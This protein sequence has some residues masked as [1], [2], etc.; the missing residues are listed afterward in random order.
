MLL[1]EFP[2]CVLFVLVVLRLPVLLRDAASHQG[3]GGRVHKLRGHRHELSGVSHNPQTTYQGQKRS[4]AAS[5]HFKFVSPP[6]AECIFIFLYVDSITQNGISDIPAQTFKLKNSFIS[7][8]LCLC[9]CWIFIGWTVTA[10]EHI[11]TWANNYS[12][13]A[14]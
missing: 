9:F 2:L 11:H 14:N 10:A 13:P 8:G 7:V 1:T 6:Q 3:H 5:S 12:N 4:N